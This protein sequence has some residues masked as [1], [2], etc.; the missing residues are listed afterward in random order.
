MRPASAKLTPD[1]KNPP[2]ITQFTK[3][4]LFSQIL[5]VLCDS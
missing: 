3:V 2:F 4:L 1:P 5:F